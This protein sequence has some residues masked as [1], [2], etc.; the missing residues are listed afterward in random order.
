[1]SAGIPQPARKFNCKSFQEFFS[2]MSMEKLNKFECTREVPKVAK[3]DNFQEILH[4]LAGHFFAG[5]TEK[6][7]Q[8]FGKGQEGWT[9]RTTACRFSQVRARG[10]REE[11][12]L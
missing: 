9:W 4:C 8:A 2:A 3:P 10:V 6:M 12:A 5:G 7:Q 1:M 11:R